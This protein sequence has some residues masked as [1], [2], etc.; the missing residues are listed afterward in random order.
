MYGT[1]VSQW[2]CRALARDAGKASSYQSMYNPKASS[3]KHFIKRW[4]KRSLYEILARRVSTDTLKCM[5]Y[6]YEPP[7]G[8][9]FPILLDEKDRQDF[10]YCWKLIYE[11]VRGVDFTEKRILVVGCGRGGDAYFIRRYM[12]A[13]SVTAIDYSSAAV[14]L[15]QRF[16][17]GSGMR[18][19]R[20]DAHQLPF[21]ADS[22]DVVVN[23]ESSHDYE[24][25]FLFYREVARVLRPDGLFLY[26]DLFRNGTHLEDFRTAG[27]EM[28]DERNLTDGVLRASEEGAELRKSILRK[29][30]PGFL[31]GSFLSWG[32]APGSR[33]YRDF[34]SGRLSYRHYRL[35]RNF[36]L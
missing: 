13:H 23:I 7:D 1:A 19:L 4:L 11:T 16:Y 26:T 21:S 25:P 8:T 36:S 32:G 6:G 17:A 29:L 34:Q 12:G 33:T 35:K 2:T 14:R 27:L 20:A 22:F 30:L 31:L 3:S 5:N 10:I 15:C 18:F 28:R 9:G 24:S